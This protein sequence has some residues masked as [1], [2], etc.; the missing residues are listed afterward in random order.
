[1]RNY[2]GRGTN[3]AKQMHF[4]ALQAEELK[5]S[6]RGSL[7]REVTISGAQ[8]IR[9]RAYYR[10]SER[11][12]SQDPTQLLLGKW[13]KKWQNR[14]ESWVTDSLIYGKSYFDFYESSFSKT[15][16]AIWVDDPAPTSKACE[17]GKEKHGFAS[18]STWCPKHE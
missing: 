16:A 11:N 14:Y 12:K 1:M 17:C 6:E 13:T 18:H 15:Y 2:I 9:K 7:G 10:R 3:L 5:S 8:P 4:S